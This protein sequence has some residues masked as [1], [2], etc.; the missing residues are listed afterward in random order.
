MYYDRRKRS[1]QGRCPGCG[2]FGIKPRWEQGALVIDCEYCEGSFEFAPKPG[3]RGRGRW[4]RR[5]G[6]QSLIT[7]R[8]V[9]CPPPLRQ[10]TLA[11]GV[12]GVT[13]VSY[14]FSIYGYRKA[15]RF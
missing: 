1:L 11:H 12:E 14:S 9:G 8:E 6:Q 2:V 3:R 13:N 4:R 10:M 5:A 7:H 15:D